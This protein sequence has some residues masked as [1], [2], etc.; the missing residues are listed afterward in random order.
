MDRLVLTDSERSAGAMTKSRWMTLRD[1]ISSTVSLGFR[2]DAVV[3]HAF[4][5][6]AFESDLFMARVEPAVMQALFDFLPP[7][8]DCVNC[9]PRGMARDI[10]QRLVSLREALTSSEIFQQVG[11]SSSQSHADTLP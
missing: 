3:T 2:V 6:T 5:K 1:E 11:I 8:A 4:H 7:L 9:T 10:L